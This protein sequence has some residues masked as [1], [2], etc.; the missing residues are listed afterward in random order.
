VHEFVARRV[1]AVGDYPRA[2]SPAWCELDDDDP[3]KLAAVLDDG[4]H[5]ALRVETA[6]QASAEAS[7]EISASIDWAREAQVI[8][9]CAEFYAA[10]PWLKRRPA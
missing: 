2:G 8:R 1:A 3:R 7:H 4:K 9:N 6:Q 5:H 10:K